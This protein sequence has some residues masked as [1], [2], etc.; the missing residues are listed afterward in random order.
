MRRAHGARKTDIADLAGLPGV[1]D[2]AI[3]AKGQ[4]EHGR[5]TRRLERL[6]KSFLRYK[7]PVEIQCDLP[8][9][10]KIKVASYN[11]V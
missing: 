7:N 1:M 5:A 10:F 9:G 6:H 2:I 11:F 3:A 8:M 4:P